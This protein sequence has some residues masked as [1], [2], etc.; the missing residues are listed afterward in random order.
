MPTL[1]A[2]HPRRSHP[3]DL[4]HPPGAL[5]RCYVVRCA[6]CEKKKLTLPGANNKDD[7]AE[8]TLRKGGWRETRKLTEDDSR[9]WVCPIHTKE[10]SYAVYKTD[11]Y[12]IELGPGDVH[13]LE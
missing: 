2:G 4:S 3:P 6:V 13:G 1:P 7:E 9:H 8:P 11:D 10:G 5:I 12:R